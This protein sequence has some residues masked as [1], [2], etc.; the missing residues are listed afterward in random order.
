MFRRL[1]VAFD[2]SSH[3]RRALREAIELAQTK[4]ARLTVIT[5]APR[6]SVWA[7]SGYGAPVSVDQL[8]QEIEL[9]CQSMLDASAEAA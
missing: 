8:A 6:P 9:S 5:V 2:G 3:A 7:F 4:G 1:L